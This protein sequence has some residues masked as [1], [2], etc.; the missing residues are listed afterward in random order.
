[1]KVQRVEADL[2]EVLELH[3]PKRNAGCLMSLRPVG[4]DFPCRGV[5]FQQARETR[6]AVRVVLCLYEGR[7]STVREAN[8]GWRMLVLALLE[9]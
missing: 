7:D 2:K 1:M 6:T 8:Q 4:C 3:Q 5:L 9:V